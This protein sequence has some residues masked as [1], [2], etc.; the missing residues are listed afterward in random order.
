MFVNSNL[1][2]SNGGGGWFLNFVL[3]TPFYRFDKLHSE[4]TK[5]NRLVVWNDTSNEEWAEFLCKKEDA[6]C[7]Q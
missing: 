7:L 1:Y 5:K 6:D 2:R 4:Q 3:H